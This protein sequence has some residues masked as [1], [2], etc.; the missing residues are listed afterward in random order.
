MAPSRPTSRSFLHR[1]RYSRVTHR[2]TVGGLLAATRVMSALPARWIA[3]L[4]DALG[5]VLWL[6]ASRWRRTARQNLRAVFG[7]Q[8]DHDER[9][10][11]A[12]EAARGAARAAL[13]LL[14]IQPLTP[15][16]YRKWV[17]LPEDLS[18]DPSFDRLRQRGGVLVSGHVGNWELLLGTRVAF[19]DVPPVTFLAEAAPHAAINEAL[20][21]LRQHGDGLEAIFR[22]GGAQAASAAVRKGGIAAL[23]VDR[24]V[25]RSQGGV[26]VP[27]LGLEARTTPL[28]AVIAQRHDVPVHPMF[29]LPIEGGRYRLWVGPDLTQGLP[30]DGDPH[31]WRRA[32]LVRLNDIFEELIRAR[33][34]LWAWSIKRYKARPT[35]E[36]GRYPP[37]SM[38]EPDR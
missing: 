19:P 29:C 6:T 27:F 26:Y 37:Y 18:D 36:L 9:R 4:G 34:E 22:E 7:D 12:R 11:I 1:L 3:P 8:L 5:T 23:L 32:L 13:L 31:A 15:E 25:R 20:A 10:R 14:H 2:L 17:D 28:P 21:R 24:N 30:Q 16:R 35:V 38:H 33:P